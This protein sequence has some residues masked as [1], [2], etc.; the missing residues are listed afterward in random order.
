VRTID[1][2]EVA[3]P[4][5]IS[6]ILDRGPFDREAET[7][8][9]KKEKIN[10]VVSKNSGGMATYPKIEA[11]RALGIPVVMIARPHKVHGDILENAEGAIVWLEQLL[12]H[13]AASGSARGV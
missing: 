10:I 8:L 7:A 1:P 11:T 2:P 13:R 6:L 9:L 3:L 12:A 4:P 5:D